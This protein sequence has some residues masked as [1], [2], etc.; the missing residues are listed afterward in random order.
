MALAHALRVIPAS[1]YRAVA[2][3]REG[4]QLVAGGWEPRFVETT[5]TVCDTWREAYDEVRAF[6]MRSGPKGLLWNGVF[7]RPSDW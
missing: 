1:R 3:V 5:I 4:H 7:I 6:M 2:L